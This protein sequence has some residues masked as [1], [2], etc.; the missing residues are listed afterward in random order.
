MPDKQS[1][2]F[3]VRVNEFDFTFTQE[4]IDAADVLK[5]SNTNFHLLQN[6]QSINAVLRQADETYKQQV[7]EIEGEAYTVQIN[8]ELDQMLDTMGYNTDVGTYSKEVKAPMPGLVLQVSVTEGQQ[9]KEGDKLLVLVAMKMENSILA[10]TNA[11]IKHI[12]VRGNQAVEKGQ[13]LMELE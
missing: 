5:L 13:L 12:A 6:N 7:L 1:F 4:A 3:Q 11:V 8:D 10:H 9:V 2:P